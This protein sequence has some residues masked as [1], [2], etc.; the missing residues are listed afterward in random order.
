[1]LELIEEERKFKK[2]QPEKKQI[3]W[4]QNDEISESE[5][6]HQL[7]ND[8]LNKF[9]RPVQ[10]LS[11]QNSE[12]T[13]HNQVPSVSEEQPSPLKRNYSLDSLNSPIMKGVKNTLVFMQ[14]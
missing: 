11:A 14:E 9:E 3:I 5:P 10:I 2:F 4:E 7:P 8:S 1:M 13:L 6:N 12:I